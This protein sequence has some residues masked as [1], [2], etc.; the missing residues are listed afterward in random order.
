MVYRVK[1]VLTN[2]TPVDAY[3]GAGRPESIYLMERLIDKAAR[4]LGEEPSELRRKNFIRPEQMPFK[5][6]AG[7]IYDSG[8]FSRVM[9]ACLK[10]GDVAGFAAR[11]AESESHG[12][13]RGLGISYYIESTMGDPTEMARIQFEDDGTVGIVVGTQS[14]GQGHA[15]AYA[16]VLVDRLGVP[17]EQ[18]R[19]IEGD[20]RALK[21][22]GGTGGSRSLTA[23]GLAI[24]EAS[25]IVIERGKHYAAQ[26]FETA[27]ADIE[28]SREE[29][30]FQVTGT[31]RRIGIMDLAA[32]S[33]SMT[34][35]DGDAA[36]MDAEATAE[37]A[38]YTFPNG[39]HLAEVEI[40]AET[41]VIE[42]VRY[43]AVDDFG[44]VVNPM[45]VAG[46]VHG[47]VVQGIVQ[48]LYEQA[49]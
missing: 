20:T 36:G 17:F 46:Q 5:T 23:E 48:A 33:R 34:P 2:T 39:C 15:T 47:G 24:R 26:E 18:V 13:R 3:R 41:G 25:E 43:T 38:Q 35:P 10:E 49:V 12:R 29:G 44:V 21:A 30:A 16:Q 27:V 22:G 31:D 7:E 42:I 40:D 32:K 11:K 37:I 14:N 19:L 4:Q 8:D 45:L 28:F 6:T 1:G 9:D